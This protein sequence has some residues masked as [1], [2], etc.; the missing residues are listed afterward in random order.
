ML[1][2]VTAGS[3]GCWVFEAEM[4]DDV[5][6]AAD[7]ELAEPDTVT[8]TPPPG[9]PATPLLLATGAAPVDVDV[10]YFPKSLGNSVVTPINPGIV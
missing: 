4:D 5:A 1:L 2:L 10:E 3:F 9:A 8:N 6:A 7:D